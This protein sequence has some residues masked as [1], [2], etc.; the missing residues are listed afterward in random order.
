MVFY[1]QSP[2]ALNLSEKISGLSRSFQHNDESL[3]HNDE[4]WN[5]YASYA[6]QATSLMSMHPERRYSFEFSS[7]P[8]IIREF[9]HHWSPAVSQTGPSPSGA[10]PQSAQSEECAHQVRVECLVRSGREGGARQTQACASMIRTHHCHN[11]SLQHARP[12]PSP[13]RAMPGDRHLC[14]QPQTRRNGQ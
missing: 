1:F 11:V 14:Q 3:Q 4:R 2:C 6:I 7:D 10:K 5:P 13:N 8:R 12:S 9:T